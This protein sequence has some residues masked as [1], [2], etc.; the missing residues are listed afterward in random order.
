MSRSLA[1]PTLEQ[2]VLGLMGRLTLTPHFPGREAALFN[3]I[4][5]TLEAADLRQ[6]QATWRSPLV[7]A[8]PLMLLTPLQQAAEG[9]PPLLRYP[10][11]GANPLVTVPHV[12]AASAS[13][14]VSAMHTVIATTANLS[15]AECELVMVDSFPLLFG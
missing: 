6:L 13:G 9:A 1:Q 4:P 7:A 15:T 8:I 11:H 10:M 12:I 14:V 2:S 5:E 3:L